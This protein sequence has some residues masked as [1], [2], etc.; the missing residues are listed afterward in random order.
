MPTPSPQFVAFVDAVSEAQDDPSQKD[1]ALSNSDVQ[2]AYSELSGFGYRHVPSQLPRGT[3]DDHTAATRRRLQ[4][5]MA[6]REAAK[7]AAKEQA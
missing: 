5:K 6:A 3:V 1:G 4:K 2:A 7:E